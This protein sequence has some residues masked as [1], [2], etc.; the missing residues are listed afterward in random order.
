MYYIIA[1]SLHLKGKKAEKLETVKSV[2]DRA[3]I[4]Y[5][6]LLTEHAGHAAEYARRITSDGNEN[7]VVAM[8]GDGTLHEILNG[9]A[10]F[11]KNSLGLIPF[12]T[13]N[14]FAHAAGIPLDVKEAAEIIAFRD[15]SHI[16]FIQLSSGL[17]SVNAVGMG[18]D[19]DVLKRVFAGK[20]RRSSKYFRALLASLC[21][22]KCFDFEAEYDGESIKRRGLIAALGNGV[23]IGGGIKLFPEAKI[24]DGYMDMII[25]DNIPRRKLIFA[26]AKL[27]RGKVNSV[28]EAKFM[29][30][31]KA[32][33]LPADE[34]FTLQAE[35]ELYENIPIEAEVISGR[36]KFYL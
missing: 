1:N 16:D 22:F 25:V 30:V 6:I 29:R 32:K 11:G 35:G 13:G 28:K 8:G 3:G 12:G 24:D 31:K 21:K 9:F 20:G 14:D 34:N 4:K 26:L 5:E 10:D 15:P 36:L 2:F 27:M 23:Q 19:V 7:T 18:I 33:I 17:R